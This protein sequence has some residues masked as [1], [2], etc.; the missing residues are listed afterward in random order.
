MDFAR[1]EWRGRLSHPPIVILQGAAWLA[2]RKK[3]HRASRR[4]PRHECDRGISRPPGVA[5]IV[6]DPDLAAARRDP[7]PRVIVERDE[8]VRTGFLAID[9]RPQS[10]VR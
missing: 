6:D 10:R 1:S 3:R 8:V 2:D 5:R 7:P 9:Q 4:E